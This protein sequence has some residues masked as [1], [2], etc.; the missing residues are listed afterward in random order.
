MIP[1][2]FL[3]FLFHVPALAAPF[4]KSRESYNGDGKAV[5]FADS[6]VPEILNQNQNATFLLLWKRDEIDDW[7]SDN[8][9]NR[10]AAFYVCPHQRSLFTVFNAM[11]VYQA[12]RRG[13]WYLAHPNEARPRWSGLEHPHSMTLQDYHAHR[14]DLGRASGELFMFP[15]NPNPLG[16]WPGIAGSPVSGP[17]GDHRVVFD[18]HGM[19]AGVAVLFAGEPQG[20]ATRLIWCYPMLEYGARDVGATAEGNPGVDEAWRD[21]FDGHYLFA[22]DPTGG[23][24][25]PP[26]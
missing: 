10:I 16:E 11:A 18:E 12:F 8:P 1:C 6:P 9:D 2:I 5:A 25:P 7:N 23:S 17:P 21:S 13:T 22:P 26:V 4:M 20:A 19:F 3:V 15:I 24:R 14:V